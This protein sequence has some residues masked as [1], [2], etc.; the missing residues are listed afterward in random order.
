LIRNG[1]GHLLCELK[2]QRQSAKS[3][4]ASDYTGL[5]DD[6]AFIAAVAERVEAQRKK[7]RRK[8]A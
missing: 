1:A 8:A 5:L 2:S 3:T 6:P 7:A 4:V